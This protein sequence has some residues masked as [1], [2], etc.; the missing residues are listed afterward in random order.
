M[1]TVA[2][3]AGHRRRWHHGIVCM[4]TCM[5]VCMQAWHVRVRECMS[6]AVCGC[7]HA[8]VAKWLENAAGAPS[9]IAPNSPSDHP[10]T[11]HAHTHEHTGARAHTCAR[12]LKQHACT[13]AR[14][15]AHLLAQVHART[16]TFAR[17]RTCTYMHG[18]RTRTYMHACTCTH[19]RHALLH[20]CTHEC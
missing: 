12:A 6:V 8:S 19:T 9:L 5:R 13:H 1:A 7:V 4:I 11:N 14:T 3:H 16:H 20:F 17:P 18:P 15:H 10:H 2:A